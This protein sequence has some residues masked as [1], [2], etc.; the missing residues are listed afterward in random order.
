MRVLFGRALD[1]EE[2]RGRFTIRL[3]WEPRDAWVGVFWNH[4]QVGAGRFLL[5]YVCLVPCLPLVLAWERP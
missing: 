3:L 5:V 1:A 2:P 4:A